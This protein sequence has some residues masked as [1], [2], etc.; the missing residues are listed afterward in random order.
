MIIVIGT[1]SCSRCTTTKNILDV[2]GIEYKYLL[3]TDYPDEN[4]NKF[5]EMAEKA[6]Q[7]SF[8]LIIKNDKI[9]TLQEAL[10]C[11]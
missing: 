8:P 1:E 2:K 9:I 6:N 4:Q 11:T 3:I 7:M 10:Q 5:M